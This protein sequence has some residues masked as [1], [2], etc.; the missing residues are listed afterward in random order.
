[1]SSNVATPFTAVRGSVPPKVALPG[2]GLRASMMPG[3]AA[4]ARFWN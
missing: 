1:M 2:F 3:V 4:V